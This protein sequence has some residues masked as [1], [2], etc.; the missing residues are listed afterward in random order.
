MSKLAFMITCFDEVNAIDVA[1]TSLRHH[2]PNEYVNV[3][4]E[5]DAKDFLFLE[6]KHNVSVIQGFD[7]QSPLLKMS[8]K[9]YDK[10]KSL[11]VET[12]VRILIDRINLTIED[13]KADYIL[14]HCPD[15]LIRGKFEI[16]DGSGLLGSCVNRYFFKATNDVLLKYGGLEVNYFGAVPAIFNTKDF[17]QAKQILENNKTLIQELCDSSCYTFS[18]DIFMSIVFSLIGKREEFNPQIIECG[19]STNWMESGC[20]IIHQFRTFYPKRKTKY[21]SQENA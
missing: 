3:F 19:R 17:L 14:L 8:D 13:S 5:G 9:D 11:K 2:Y 15:T 18:H 7:S 10:T 1:L 16:P 20:P 4:C 6:K 21:K 12:A